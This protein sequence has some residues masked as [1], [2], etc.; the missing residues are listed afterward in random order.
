MRR[1]AVLALCAALVLTGCQAPGSTGGHDSFDA[2][3]DGET[4]T[5]Q[6]TT[7]ADA[8]P[9]PPS[10]RLGWE[11]GYWHN[12]SIPVTT[13][14]G[15]NESERA[16]VV[17]RSMA[18]V[19]YVRR[20]EFDTTVPVGL[21]SR[22]EYRN[23]SGGGAG[24]SL[25]RFDN[26]K[27]EALLLVGEDRGSTAAQDSTL[28]E[29]V[30]GFYSGGRDEIVLV[31]ESETPTIDEST[32]AHELVHALQDQQFG[33]GSDARTRDGV[34]G[35]NGLIEGDATATQQAYDARCGEQWDCLAGGGG[36]G[37]GGNGDR[38]FGI[39]FMLYFPY[40]DGPGLVTHLR[41]Q[42]G[43]AAVGDAY[44]DRPDGAREVISPSEYPDWEPETVALQ[45]RTS[46]DWERVRPS[47]DRNRPDYAV[48]GPSAIAASLAYTLTDDYNE[49]S[50]VAATEVINFEEGGSVDSSD[51]Y[52]YDLPATDGWAGGRMHVYSDGSETAY[53]WRTVWDS[54]RDAGEFAAAWEAALA[55]WGGTE[56]ADGT[57]VIAENSPFADAV[58]VQVDGRTV[59]VVNAP[60]AD[61]LD[62][63]HDA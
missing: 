12:E 32:L 44:G 24:D 9:D 6:P 2:S 18:R 8:P 11:N 4:A 5:V 23:R 25:R 10:D 33:L 62:E 59:T 22:A 47:E 3:S 31:T 58:A 48:V 54:E 27:F 28:G 37:G 53:V 42:G 20:L 35:R 50:V 56:R 34:Q 57:W 52:N 36:S 61:E 41:D 15:L 55:H 39:N 46:D 17:A 21:V 51:P 19:E 49:S 13:E 40:S 26:A 38:H 30:L 60:T 45:D 63:V 7:A 1:L 14:D 43:W 29:S 16:A